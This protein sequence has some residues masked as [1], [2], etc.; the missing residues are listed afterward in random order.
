M[1]IQRM[2]LG[3]YGSFNKYVTLRNTILTHPY[4]IN[5][6]LSTS[7]LVESIIQPSFEKVREYC[8]VPD[9]AR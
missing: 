2:L 6:N 7:R 3:F 5:Q 4:T 1:H 9:I 8:A